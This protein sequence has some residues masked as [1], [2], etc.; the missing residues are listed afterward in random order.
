VRTTL[1]AV[2]LG[3]LV[4]LLLPGMDA[5]GR[6][7]GFPASYHTGARILVGGLWLVGVAAVWAYRPSEA[8]PASGQEEG[9][10]DGGAGPRSP[11]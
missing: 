1:W 2:V 3:A 6:L 7:M 9:P 10:P 5:L 4:A 11:P 8:G